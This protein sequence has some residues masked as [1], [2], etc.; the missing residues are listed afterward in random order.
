MIKRVN[1][2]ITHSKRVLRS[3]QSALRV[4]VLA[5]SKNELLAK[6]PMIKMMTIALL[7]L[8]R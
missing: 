5:A 4:Q 1:S 2:K 6:Q 3:V 8:R 7:L